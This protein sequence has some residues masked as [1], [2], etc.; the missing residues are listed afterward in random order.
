MFVTACYVLAVLCWLAG[1]FNVTI[2]S[3]PK[4]WAPNWLC[5][6]LFFVGLALWI[7]PLL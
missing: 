7:A 5:G 3:A 6:G 2:G 4:T 1:F